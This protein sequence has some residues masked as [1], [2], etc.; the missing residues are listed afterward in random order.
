MLNIVNKLV[1]VLA[2]Y[3]WATVGALL[4]LEW[5]KGSYAAWAKK[6]KQ[7]AESAKPA[8][9]KPTTLPAWLARDKDGSLWL[10]MDKPCKS[11]GGVMWMPSD[12]CECIRIDSSLFPNITF[13][14]SP[15]EIMITLRETPTTL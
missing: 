5:V 9:D 11:I 14:N 10:F 13:E 15:K 3:S 6:R 8:Q 7:K 1:V 12:D 2:L 4:I